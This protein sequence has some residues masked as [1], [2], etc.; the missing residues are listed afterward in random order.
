MGGGGKGGRGWFECSGESRLLFRRSLGGVE[1][2][3]GVGTGEAREGEGRGEGGEADQP[4]YVAPK[5]GKE[6]RGQLAEGETKHNQEG[7]P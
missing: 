3:R 5:S 2:A 1:E 7:R 6:I 4:T